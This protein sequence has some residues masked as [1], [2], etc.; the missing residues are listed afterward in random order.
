M[1]LSARAGGAEA[2]V[3]AVPE[4]EVTGVVAVVVD[5]LGAR[6]AA[7]V[8]VGGGE[9]DEHEFVRAD[10]GVAE[11]YGFGGEPQCRDVHRP[12][13]AQVFPKAAGIWSG[14]ARS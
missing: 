13:M 10:G 8:A 9:G 14:C 6:E 12:E 7:G 1:V 3:D 11:G 4:R 5:Q 2:D